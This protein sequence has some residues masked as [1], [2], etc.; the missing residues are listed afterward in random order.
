VLR[1]AS[2]LENIEKCISGRNYWGILLLQ[3]VEGTPDGRCDT[4]SPLCKDWERLQYPDGALHICVSVITPLNILASYSFM[5][6]GP[7]M[8]GLGSCDC[9]MVCGTLRRDGIECSEFRRTISKGM[10]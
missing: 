4:F 5:D 6:E 8:I 9:P 2:V 1:E 3:N 7:Q 10:N